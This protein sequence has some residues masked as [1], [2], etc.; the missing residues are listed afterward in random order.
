MPLPP[1]TLF[2]L[3]IRIIIFSILV[4]IGNCLLKLKSR[5]KFKYYKVISRVNSLFKFNNLNFMT[6]I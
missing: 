6:P 5:E 3:I 1:I 2:K 4:V